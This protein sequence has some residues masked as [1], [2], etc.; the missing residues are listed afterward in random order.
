MF[1]YPL[2]EKDK[3]WAGY[4]RA[5]GSIDVASGHRVRFAQTYF[6]PVMEFA[7]YIGR[8]DA[9]K[10]GCRIS[11]Y[12]FHTLHTVGSSAAGQH[13][14]KLGVK[15]NPNSDLYLSKHFWRGLIDGDGSLMCYSR[16]KP[17]SRAAKHARISLIATHEDVQHFQMFIVKHLGCQGYVYFRKNMAYISLVGN[18]AKY[19]VELLYGGGYTA[20]VRKLAVADEIMGL[21]WRTHST[22]WQPPVP[23]D[24]AEYSFA[25]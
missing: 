9:V 16:G 14:A 17:G 10:S 3:Y 20:N 1:T 21:P 8:P 11:N 6:H 12:G 7:R 2:T 25:A 4:I 15:K 18:Q 19:M 22:S 13:L 23:R 24:E 5:D